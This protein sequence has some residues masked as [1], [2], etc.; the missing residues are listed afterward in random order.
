MLL[1]DAMSKNGVPPDCVCFNGAISACARGGRWERALGLLDE[2]QLKGHQPNLISY[3]SAI[4]ACSKGGCW[5]RALQLLHEMRQAG[6]WPNVITLSA[7]INIQAP[8]FVSNLGSNIGGAVSS[9]GK[10]NKNN[11]KK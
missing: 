8:S 5:E 3:S 9:V 1:L 10:I 4:S 2:M 7:A 6:H 11:R